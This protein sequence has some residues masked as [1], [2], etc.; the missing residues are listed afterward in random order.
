MLRFTLGLIP[1][2]LF[3]CAL[4][5]SLKVEKEIH[6]VKYGRF[7]SSKSGCQICSVT[8]YLSRF[9]SVIFVTCILSICRVNPLYLHSYLREQVMQEW[10][11]D[12]NKEIIPNPATL[13]YTEFLLATADGKIGGGKGAGKIVTPFEKTKVAAYT[14]G[15]MTPRIR[16]FA[17]LG[18]ELQFHMQ[19]EG[20][21][22]P[23]KKWVD[24]YSSA[25]FEVS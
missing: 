3:S 13:K 18:K 1:I 14:V 21:G 12:P 15:A 25:S 4:T 8:D 19:Y 17:F 22:H 2:F 6:V 20:N 23:Y 24:T 9:L 5:A 10:G 16:L 7:F 11:I